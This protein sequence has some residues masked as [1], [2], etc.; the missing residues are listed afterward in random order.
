M[1]KARNKVVSG[2]YSGASVDEFLGDVSLNSF[3]TN[4]AINKNT[5][6]NIELLDSA[7]K[8]DT[9]SSIARGL[10]GGVLLGPVGII[11]GAMLGKTNGIHLI[12]I[13]FKNGKRSLIEVDDKI[14]KKLLTKLY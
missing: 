6:T 7:N 12:S 10:V 9:G 1:T 14:Y 11:G 3:T 4:V 8:K 2:D 13:I 5:I